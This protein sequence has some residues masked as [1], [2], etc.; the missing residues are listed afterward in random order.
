LLMICWGMRATMPS[1]SS[2]NSPCRSIDWPNDHYAINLIGSE[3]SKCMDI[4]I[5]YRDNVI[6]EPNEF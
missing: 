2:E 1:A 5:N 3:W 4:P 6:C